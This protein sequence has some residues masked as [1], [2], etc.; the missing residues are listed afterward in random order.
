MKFNL[1]TGRQSE[2]KGEKS[3]YQIYLEL[4]CISDVDGA[5]QWLKVLQVKRERNTRDWTGDISISSRILYYW[6]TSPFNTGAFT[7]FTYYNF[8][9]RIK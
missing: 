3:R 9:P 6:A 7:L 8:R 4:F 2:C 1:E 5:I